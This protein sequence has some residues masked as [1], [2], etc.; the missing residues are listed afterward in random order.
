MEHITINDRKYA[1]EYREETSRTLVTISSEE[2]TEQDT[3]NVKRLGELL[4][5]SVRGVWWDSNLPQRLFVQKTGIDE[6][7]VS[8]PIEELKARIKECLSKM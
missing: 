5:Q 1:F 4:R 2:W 7:P 8:F 3:A 6:K